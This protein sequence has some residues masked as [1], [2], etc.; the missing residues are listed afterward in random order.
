MEDCNG[1][2]YHQYEVVVMVMVMVLLGKRGND[3]RRASL[4]ARNSTALQQIFI[5]FRSTGKHKQSGNLSRRLLRRRV[6][7]VLHEIAFRSK[8][9]KMA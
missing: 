1:S 6:Y 8:R 4:V 7:P 5:A 3:S 2:G 9:A